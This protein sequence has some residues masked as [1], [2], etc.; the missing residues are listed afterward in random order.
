MDTRTHTHTHT[1]YI[2]VFTTHTH[3]PYIYVFLPAYTCT[4][5]CRSGL[6]P[7]V[8]TPHIWRSGVCVCVRLRMMYVCVCVSLCV[9]DATNRSRMT[10]AEWVLGTFLIRS[11]RY[12]AHLEECTPCSALVGTR[13]IW[14]RAHPHATTRHIWRS[15]HCRH[16]WRS[17]HPHRHIR[18]HTHR[19]Q[20]QLRRG[21]T[22][23]P[24]PI[25]TQTM[26]IR[27]QT[28]RKQTQV[29]VRSKHTHRMQTQ[30]SENADIGCRHNGDCG[31][32]TSECAE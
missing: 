28:H 2:C 3:T 15:V 6:A 4:H 22:C 13:H 12:S 7:K 16:I 23:V 20:T 1:P 21:C 10:V 25:Q 11:V 14:R 5:T 8:V 9:S 19:M 29:N 31:A 18:M 24:P 17:A 27:M 26:H 32:T 30:G